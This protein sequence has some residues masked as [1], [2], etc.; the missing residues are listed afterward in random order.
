[1]V[2]FSNK[3]EEFFDFLIANAENFEQGTQLANEVMKDM[4]RIS[5]NMDEISKLEHKADEINRQVIL[6]LSRVFI[7]PIDREDFYS[8]ACTLENCVDSIHSTLMRVELYH[9]DTTT[10]AAIQMSELLVTMAG[11]VKELCSLLKN[12]DRNEA[13]LMSRAEHLSQLESMADQVYRKEMSRIFEGEI[14]VLEIIKWRDILNS[15]EN[16]ADC[17]ERLSNTI[18]EVVMKYA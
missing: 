2:S 5:A 12:I 6:K 14:P 7:T 11:E 16:V 17:V 18:K 8:L 15:M 4:A 13:E 9:I 10:P 3:H 1:M